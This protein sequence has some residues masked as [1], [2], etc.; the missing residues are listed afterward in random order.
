M[1]T[2]TAS[3]LNQGTPSAVPPKGAAG[4]SAPAPTNP[5]PAAAKKAAAAPATDTTV[6]KSAAEMRAELKRIN[7][8]FDGYATIEEL[9]TVAK[10]GETRAS[11]E[12]V[13]SLR[14]DTARQLVEGG[15]LIARTLESFQDKMERQM[16]AASRAPVPLS[17]VGKSQVVGPVRVEHLV[18]AAVGGGTG[19]AVVMVLEATSTINPLGL[20]AKI[21]IAAGS[22]LAGAGAVEAWSRWGP[23]GDEKDDK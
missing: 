6:S 17:R 13:A 4:A 14:H 3:A 7:G 20:G 22:A 18:G 19:I 5:K 1:A 9:T 2:R 21:G 8:R 15:A 12:E 23:S 11:K 10:N 16:K